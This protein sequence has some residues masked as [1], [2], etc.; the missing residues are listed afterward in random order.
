[1]LSIATFMRNF[2]LIE[3]SEYVPS[4][5]ADVR[6]YCSSEPHRIAMKPDILRRKVTPIDKLT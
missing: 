2:C 3:G 4:G 6:K 5:G 1:M